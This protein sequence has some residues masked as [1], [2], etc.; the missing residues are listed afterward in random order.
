MAL[1]VVEVVE[2]ISE[3]KSRKAIAAQIAMYLKAH[4]LSSDTGAP[5]MK[6]T[7]DDCHMV[8]EE[9]IK[10]F[11]SEMSDSVDE[12]DAMQVEYENFMAQDPT[13]LEEAIRKKTKKARR[14]HGN[15][16]RKGGDQPSAG[17]SE[18]DAGG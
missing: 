11:I 5:E 12:S 1:K 10:L 17:D 8:P 15:G 2:K 3:L 14:T 7:R 4:Y 6:I 13:E 16:T 9:H 18:P